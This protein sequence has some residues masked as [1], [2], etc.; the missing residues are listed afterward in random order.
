LKILIFFKYKRH[1]LINDL[2][3]DEIKMVHSVSL[4]L[5]EPTRWY[6]SIQRGLKL[7]EVYRTPPCMGGKVREL[8]EEQ[9]KL[10]LQQ[11]Q[12]KYKQQHQAQIENKQN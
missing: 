3:A 11:Q 8:A 7:D 6:N 12:Q 4:R 10:Q 9:Y 2:L 5:L 1:K